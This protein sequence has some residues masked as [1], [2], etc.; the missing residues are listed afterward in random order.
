MGNGVSNPIMSDKPT[1][2]NAK[3][4]EY[5]DACYP[6]GLPEQNKLHVKSAFMS[7]A[8][9]IITMMNDFNEEY[10]DG[11]DDALESFM[12]GIMDELKAYGEERGID[13]GGKS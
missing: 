8:L 10:G 5:M 6:K 13:M 2:I 3:F 12:S 11:A 9:A 4:Q 7:G 1:T